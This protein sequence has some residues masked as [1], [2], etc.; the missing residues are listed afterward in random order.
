M[1]RLAIFAAALI[2]GTPLVTGAHAQED[3]DN[4]NLSVPYTPHQETDEERLQN[5]QVPPPPPPQPSPLDRAVNTYNNLP[6]KP[7]YNSNMHAPMLQYET[8]Y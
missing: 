1:I 7:A 8:H 2:A 3:D 4:A 6:V 5:F